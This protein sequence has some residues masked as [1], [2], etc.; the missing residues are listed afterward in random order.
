MN[1]AVA[2]P[3]YLCDRLYEKLKK[4]GGQ[5]ADG[6]KAMQL[7]RDQAALESALARIIETVNSHKAKGKPDGSAVYLELRDTAFAKVEQFCAKHNVDRLSIEAQIPAL[8]DL[9]ARCIAKKKT[10]LGVQLIAALL[11]GIVTL[12]LIGMASG[13]V[14]A[15]HNW[16]MH[17]LSH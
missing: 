5:A 2:K 7:K 11:G 4:L 15:G 14:S 6:F 3:D 9:N 8:S 1:I 12:L 10:P 16:V 13:L 17:L